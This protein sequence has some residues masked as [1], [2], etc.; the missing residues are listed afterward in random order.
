VDNETFYHETIS[1]CGA[2]TMPKFWRLAAE[3]LVAS[4]TLTSVTV[5]CYRLHFNLAANALLLMIF[6]VLTARLGSFFSSIFA[7]VVAA[8]CLTYMVPPAFSFR[9]TDPLDGVAIIAFLSTSFIVSRLMARV[10]KQAAEALSSAAIVD[11]SEDAIVSKS[12]EGIITNWNASA[13]RLFGYTARE[14]IGQHI[15]LIIPLDRRDEETVIIERIKRGERIEHFDSVRVGKDKKPI[16]ISLTI[17]PVRDVSGKI[18]GASKIARDIT[19]RKRM[20]RELQ[21][22]EERY[23][24]LAD[25]LDT[26]VQFRTQGLERRNLELRALTAVLETREE[27]L[28]TFVKHVPA[29]VAMLDRDMRYLQVSNRWCADF[30]LDSSQLLGRSHY[31]IFP[32]LPERWRQIHRRCLEGE[33]LRADEDRWDRAGGT[34]WLRWEMRPWQNLNGVRGGVLIFSEDI[35]HR[36]HA[37]EALVSLSGRLIE[38]QDEERK[39]IAREIHDDYSQRIA[40]LAMDLEQ[41]AENVGDSFGETSQQFHDLFDRVSELGA[42]L[43]SLSH[44]L[45]SSTLESLGLLAGVEAFCKEFAEQQGM[46]VDFVHENIPRRV[47]SDAALCMFRITQ[48]ALRNIK[49]HSGAHQAEVHLEQQDGRLHLSVSDCGRGF[50]SSKPPAECGIGIH[51]MEERLRLLGGKLEIQSRP[52]EGTRIDAWLPLK[53]ASAA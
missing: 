3:C 7:S 24:A 27:L 14:A 2:T 12:L 41:L 15:S 19:K 49:R 31:E 43:H 13:E 39:R 32:D 11:S 23:R 33:T 30:S 53:M 45:H 29:A 46:K 35:T 37:E 20:E 9:V 26:Q 5:V 10:R 38:A 4:L 22:S 17:S 50:D 16:E 51:S 36:K 34:T 44:R 42:D 18:I 28:K 1:L 52:M 48:E 25:A 47:P 8:V 21:E 6:V 40:M